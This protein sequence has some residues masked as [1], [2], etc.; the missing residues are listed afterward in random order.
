MARKIV[1]CSD[2]TG[3][4]FSKRVSNITRLIKSLDLS[5]PLTQAVFY[6]QG[7]G[8]NPSLV[9]AVKAYKAEAGKNREGLQI[10]PAPKTL[11]LFVLRPF[12]RFAGLAL[13]YGLRDNVKEMYKALAKCYDREEDGRVFLFGFSRGAFTVRVLAGLIYRCGLPPKNVADDE[14]HFEKC[15]SEAYEIY[16]PH[17]EDGSRI[18]RFKE[19][20]NVRDIEISFLGIWDTVKSYGGIWPQSLPHLRHNP[21]VNTVCHALALDER[22]SWFVPTS[23]G[24]IDL[25]KKNAHGIKPDERYARQQVKEVW[26]SG[27]H[28]DVG[29]GDEEADTA[30]V[31]FRWMLKEASASGLILNQAGEDELLVSDPRDPTEVHESLTAGWYITEIIP[32]WELDNTY[33]PPKRLF[34]WG[35][36]GKRCPDKFRRNGE[37]FRHPSVVDSDIE[38][39][40]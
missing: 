23:W 7:I 32:R 29:G 28:S 34:R 3:N 11:K 39:G 2:G 27:C 38:C 37:I 1:I 13:G 17:W 9:K 4:T 35:S 26:F 18:E 31:P 30:R 10:L 40:Y 20:Y 36:T 21:I 16:M 15:F 19:A 24:G 33:R 5:D 8:T 6:D 22:R 12:T 14:A 25:D